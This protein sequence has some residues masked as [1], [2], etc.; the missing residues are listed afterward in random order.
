MDTFQYGAQDYLL[1]VEY[2]SKYPEIG[3]LKDKTPKSVI[4]ILKSIL[5]H[6]GIPKFITSENMPFVSK[7]FRPFANSW[8]IKLQTSSPT[9]PKSNGISERT[10]QTVQKLLWKATEANTDPHHALLE[11][12]NS[13]ISGMCKSLAQ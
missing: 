10:I 7:E 2:F 11:Y 9:Y 5:A 6:D 8:D 13:P 3:V 4:V 1:V 12:S